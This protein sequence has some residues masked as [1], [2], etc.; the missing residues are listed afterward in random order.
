MR[1]SIVK[2]FHANI[3]R[4]TFGDG[5]LTVQRGL[6]VLGASGEFATSA[7]FLIDVRVLLWQI[8]LVKCGRYNS[9]SHERQPEWVGT[10]VP[11]AN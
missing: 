2:N 11:G 8:L 3:V 1:V 4:Q 7:K 9:H 5:N 6:L 10:S